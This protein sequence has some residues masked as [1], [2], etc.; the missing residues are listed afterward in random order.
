MVLRTV[1]AIGVTALASVVLILLGV[2]YFMLAIWII[3]IGATWAGY[4]DVGGEMV[5]L[6]AGLV[7]AASLIGSAIQR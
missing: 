4:P 7:T 5:V 1:A 2:L 6:T 3:K